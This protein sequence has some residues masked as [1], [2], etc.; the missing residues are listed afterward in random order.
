M[1]QSWVPFEH[2]VAYFRFFEPVGGCSWRFGVSNC[3]ISAV[4][5]VIGF[6]VI[7]AVAV[8]KQRQFATI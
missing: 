3:P 2:Q 8:V 4:A 5:A 1:K 7:V 6:A